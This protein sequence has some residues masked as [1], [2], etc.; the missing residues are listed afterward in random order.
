MST[1]QEIQAIREADYIRFKHYA[2]LGF[3]VASPIL[4]AL[5]PRRLDPLTV[6]LTSAFFVS[7]NHITH[8]RTGR[9][10]VDR[11]ESKIAY[12][13]KAVSVPDLP[14]ERALELQARMRAARDAQ[15]KEGGL[16]SEELEKLKARQEQEKGMAERI[17]MGGEVEGWK[18]RR[19]R[20]EREALEEGRGYGDLIKEHIWDVWTWGKKDEE[21]EDDD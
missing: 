4:I 11:I 5:P 18:E 9:S 13:S 7:A 14:S 19:L 15:I 16:V 12:S 8:E 21:D 6:L 2:A 17:W 10:I 3:L 1:P 20:E